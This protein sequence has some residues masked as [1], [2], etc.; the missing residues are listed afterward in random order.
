MRLTQLIR[1]W[2]SRIPS[3]HRPGR[4]RPF[5]PS[6]ESLEGRNVPST[7]LVTNLN[8][9]GPGSLRAAILSVNHDT[10]NSGVDEIDFKLSGT[11]MH[12]IKLTTELPAV[13]HPVFLNGGSQRAYAGTPLV[14][15]DGG[16]IP[17]G[18]DGL[19]IDARGH[20]SSFSA[21]VMGLAFRHVRDGI[22]V[23][24]D[25]SSTALNVK[26]HDNQ[27]TAQGG[28]GINISAGTTSATVQVVHNQVT[29]S[30]GGD[31]IVALTAGTSDNFKFSGNTVR[32]SGSGD[33]IQV[34]GTG[35]DNTLAFTQNKVGLRGTGD[36]LVIAVTA[37]SSTTASITNNNLN[38]AYLG[39][40][41][42]LVGGSGFQAL[43]QGN[44]FRSN[45]VGVEVE[46]DGNTAGS[47]DLGGGSL[48]GTGGNNFTTFGTATANSFAIGLFNVGP[49]Y[50]LPALHNLFAVPA[51]STIADGSYD[52]NAGGEGTIL[53]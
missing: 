45:L 33:G 13:T 17:G 36:A 9:A 22:Q 35:A 19:T 27:I 7:F 24:D 37:S 28:E 8:N 10:A 31:G 42:H 2:K 1:R 26:L 29:T 23:L 20:G 46:G 6:L 53:V 21:E 14:Q 11:G 39:T 5:R 40:G 51:T 52:P 15:I 3:P 34:V 25:Q 41:L 12:T 48:G 50:Q 44:D 43:V 4:P 32:V 49:D 18:G 30:A 47:I 16:G 38:T